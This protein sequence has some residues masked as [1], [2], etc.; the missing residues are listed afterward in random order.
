M[1]KVNT[2]GLHIFY[3]SKTG[4]SEN[5]EVKIKEKWGTPKD[6]FLKDFEKRRSRRILKRRVKFGAIVIIVIAVLLWI[7]SKKF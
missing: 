3:Y 4:H 5:E 7:I 1:E 6:N 2:G